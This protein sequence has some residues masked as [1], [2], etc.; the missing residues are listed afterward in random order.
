VTTKDT[1]QCRINF[2]H[3]LGYV[4]SSP[5]TWDGFVC[6]W[7][8]LTWVFN[9]NGLLT[10]LI[11]C[12]FAGRLGNDCWCT[13]EQ[14]RFHWS[15]LQMFNKNN[16]KLIWNTHF[17]PSCH[18]TFWHLCPHCDILT[19][20]DDPITRSHCR[21]LP[22]RNAKWCCGMNSTINQTCF[23][24]TQVFVVNFNNFGMCYTL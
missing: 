7:T 22:L 3:V 23:E 24:S 9:G 13:Q 14:A 18:V 11:R 5:T 4:H 15:E 1:N 10:L 17:P 2:M 8:C 12:T 21:P 16:I 19:D 20:W 6:K